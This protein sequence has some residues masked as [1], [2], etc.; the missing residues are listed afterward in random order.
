M[1]I[2]M[3]KARLNISR[4][5]GVLGRGGLPKLVK[6]EYGWRGGVLSLQEKAGKVYHWA[7]QT[8]LNKMKLRISRK[9]F[10]FM[11]CNRKTKIKIKALETKSAKN[12]SVFSIFILFKVLRLIF[13]QQFLIYFFFKMYFFL[14]LLYW[15]VCTFMYLCIFICKY[16][17]L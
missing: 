5:T 14:C 11:L 16:I 15:V 9:I 7:G 8:A 10:S 12:Y 2:N 13:H 4:T 6:G 3:P 1:Y 17:Y